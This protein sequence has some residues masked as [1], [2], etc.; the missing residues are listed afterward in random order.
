[1]NIGI[2]A[3][4]LLLAAAFVAM[5]FVTYQAVTIMGH[6]VAGDI[7]FGDMSHPWR[8]Q[9]N[10]DFGFHLLIMACWMIYRARNLPLGILWGIL[11]IFLGGMFSFAYLLIATFRANGDMRILLL[12][13]HFDLPKKE[14]AVD[15]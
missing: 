10:V 8:A 13:R 5:A 2:W 4:R 12:G 9:F 7:F 14:G 11:S 15:V 6:D 1:M 3:F